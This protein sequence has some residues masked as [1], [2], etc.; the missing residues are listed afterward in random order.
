MR[1]VFSLS[2]VE[3]LLLLIGGAQLAQGPATVPMASFVGTW[4]GTQT[5][6]IENPPPSARG[7]QQVE[8]TIDLAD[9]KLTG[10]MN[11]WFGGED[12]ATFTN[13]NVVGDELRA[14]AM[15]GKP[16]EAGQ[17]VRRDW[18]ST[19][20]IEFRFK[21]QPNNQLVGTADV[22]LDKTQWTKFRYELGKKRSRY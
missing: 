5:W 7:E 19:V 18:K 17:R 16:P 1:M 10:F 11:P 4:V 6:A 9:G 20:T 22:M 8:L 12:G 2:I 3:A 13:V 14:T 15:I 21:T